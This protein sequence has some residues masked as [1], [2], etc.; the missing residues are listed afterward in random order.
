MRKIAM[1]AI[2]AIAGAVALS[3]CSGKVK[4]ETADEVSTPRQ[5]LLDRLELIAKSGRCAFGH[6]DDTAYGKTWRGERGR[7]DVLEVVGDYPAVMNWDLGLIELGEK[8]ELDGVPFDFIREEVA[9]QDARG[10]INT[11]SWHVRNPLTG[12]DAWD[13]SGGDVVLQCVTDSTATNDTIKAWIGRAADFIGAL[14]D[15]ADNRIP[16]VFRPWHEHTG[17]WF[18]WGGNNTTPES[19]KKLWHLTRKIF[20]EKG[21]D[22]VVWA[23]SP[24]KITSVEEYLACYPGDDYV[25]IMGADVYHFDGEKG[26]DQYV[27][28]VNTTLDIACKQAKEHGKLAAFTETGSEGLPLANWYT[29]QLLPLLKKYPVIYVT[30]WRNADNKPGHFYAP[31][32]GH[33]AVDSFKA[34]AADS[35]ILFA[36][37]LAKIK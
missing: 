20:D 33:P 9:A 19:Y 8:D 18:W 16:V 6:H 5:Q 34:F 10:G 28:R 17:S 23:Y 21:I 25:D 13:V 12:G 14:R 37:E 32:P 36:K 15:S 31:Y 35:T 24:D 2:T 3:G 1:F 22:N 7:S 26:I 30:V 29:E 11:I 4:A 27:S